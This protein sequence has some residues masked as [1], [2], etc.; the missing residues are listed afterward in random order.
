MLWLPVAAFAQ[1]G[2]GGQTDLDDLQAQYASVQQR[3]T[4]ARQA[5]PALATKL[6]HEL[7][8]VG[9]DLTYL[10]VRMRRENSVPR[11]EISAIRDRLAA[12]EREANGTTLR[13]SA[14]APRLGNSGSGR[15]STR[16]CRPRSVRRPPRSRTGSRPRRSSTCIRAAR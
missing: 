7:S 3:V 14:P 1:G 8:L 6:E 15:N 10:R 2:P 16:D 5:D 9:E 12:L 11:G 4:A 13:E